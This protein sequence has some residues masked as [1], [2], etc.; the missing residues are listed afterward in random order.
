M[1]YI[2]LLCEQK[3]LAFGNLDGDLAALF[4]SQVTIDLR[5]TRILPREEVQQAARRH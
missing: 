4:I 2:T 1:M 5:A 3:V